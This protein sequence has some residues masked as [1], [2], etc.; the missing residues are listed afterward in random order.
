[1]DK[2]SL[3][4]TISLT[5]SITALAFPRETGV[6]NHVQPTKV[7]TAAPPAITEEGSLRCFDGAT[8]LHTTDCTMGTP[9]SF[10]FKPQT[11]ITCDEGY[12]PSVWHPDHCIEVSTCFPTDAD[13]I[14]TECS[15]GALPVSTKTLMTTIDGASDFETYCMPT[16]SCS[17]GMTTSMSINEYC[18][19]ASADICSGLPPHADRC[20]CVGRNMTPVYP[21]GPGATATG[22]E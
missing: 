3:I 10:C 9:V 8:I 12:F 1:M 15:N 17:P 19:T 21:D 5:F 16:R 13:W 6:N 18:A 7:V 11:P 14:T 2:P 20:E 22:C 4:L